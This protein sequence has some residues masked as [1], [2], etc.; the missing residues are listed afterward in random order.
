VKIEFNDILYIEGLKDYIKI[1]C[2]NKPVLTKSTL[3]NIEEKL[4]PD[5]FVR[6]HKSYIV[7]VKK[8]RKI[9]N[10]RI[11]IGE[12]RIPIGDQYKDQF[13]RRLNEMML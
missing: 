4:P 10:G 8:I 3:K 7:S 2:G 12:T 1:F 9:E 13:Q 6:V 11:L 5:L